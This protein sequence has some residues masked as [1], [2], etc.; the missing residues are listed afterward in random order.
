MNADL[1]IL[2]AFEAALASASFGFPIA[3]SNVQFAPVVGK[4]YL[5]TA[6]LP[7][8]SSNPTRGDGFSRKPGIFQVTVVA[9][10]GAGSA[11]ALTAAG[12]IVAEFPRGRTLFDADGVRVIVSGAASVAKGFA[13]TPW[14]RVPVSIY[15]LADVHAA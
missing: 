11:A 2:R 15:F 1:I 8:I 9:P 4:M 6:Y 5:E 13:D 7:A 12:D 10:A 14:Y 3:Y